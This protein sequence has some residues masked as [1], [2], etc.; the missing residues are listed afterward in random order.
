[1]TPITTSEV[2]A[3]DDI[4]PHLHCFGVP[5]AILYASNNPKH[6]LIMAR[7]GSLIIE[8]CK[9]HEKI[10]ETPLIVSSDYM[11]DGDWVYVY[12]PLTC[13]HGLLVI[14]SDI[15]GEFSCI[16]RVFLHHELNLC[17]WGLG[18][19]NMHIMGSYEEN[20]I[21]R[22]QSF[23]SARELRIRRYIYDFNLINRA[24][25]LLWPR[26]RKANWSPA[27]VRNICAY[28]EGQIDAIPVIQDIKYVIMSIARPSWLSHLEEK[29]QL[30]RNDLDYGLC[31]VQR[32]RHKWVSTHFDTP[33]THLLPHRW[34]Y[35]Y[36]IDFAHIDHDGWLARQKT[37]RASS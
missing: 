3:K 25:H 27:L 2:D 15:C 36:I 37:T 5:K 30:T 22:A 26:Y 32:W 13:D 20:E 28:H 17:V 35:W 19:I 9:S 1:M 23:G 10:F 11:P 21:M 7:K 6:K 34:D 18:Y 16:F 12:Q 29:R 4:N 8:L 24:L 33:Q 14:K 31:L